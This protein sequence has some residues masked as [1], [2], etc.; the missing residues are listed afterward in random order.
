MS[1]DKIILRAFLSTLASIASMFAILLCVLLVF[2]PATMMDL[3]YS[4]GME[5][6]SITQAKRAY[7]RGDDIHYIARAVETAIEIEDFKQIEVCGLKMI[8]DEDF[9]VYCAEKDGVADSSLGEYDDYIYGEIGVAKYNR[10]KKTEAVEFVFANT[11]ET[12]FPRNN[13]IVAVFL[14]SLRV[15]DM[16]TA[17]L[18]KGK[19]DERLEKLSQADREYCEAILAL[20]SK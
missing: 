10:G 8:A 12:A 17:N 3:T 13:G 15:E 19:M 11:Q 9:S 2:F 7:E 16:E 18:I 1:V 14:T 6:W 5:S 20:I 4:L